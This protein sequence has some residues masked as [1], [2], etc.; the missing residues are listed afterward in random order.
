MISRA[1]G[2]S[3]F[4]DKSQ[5]PPSPQSIYVC[6]YGSGAR[7]Q[8]GRHENVGTQRLSWW[9]KC[10]TISRSLSFCAE[11]PFLTLIVQA[12]DWWAGRQ[13]SLVCRLGGKEL[14]QHDAAEISIARRKHI[15]GSVHCMPPI[16]RIRKQRNSSPLGELAQQW[17][18]IR[19]NSGTS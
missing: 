17:H 15:A 3:A 14:R 7:R 10:A 16:W 8:Q 6:M 1:L 18:A 12:G 9:R 2:C 13:G 19:G 11:H 5:G 4:C